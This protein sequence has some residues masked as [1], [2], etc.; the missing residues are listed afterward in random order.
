[1]LDDSFW[2]VAESAWGRLPLGPDGLLEGRAVYTDQEMARLL[3]RHPTPAD[4][5]ALHALK[6]ATGGVLTTTYGPA[7]ARPSVGAPRGPAVDPALARQMC[8]PY[9]ALLAL[10]REGKLPACD[11]ALCA[12]VRVVDANTKVLACFSELADIC[13]GRV[14]A[15]RWRVR[16]QERLADLARLLAWYTEVVGDQAAS[17]PA[18]A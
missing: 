14:A 13:E 16:I 5:C 18:A 9:Q 12:G 11:L 1:V 2:L 4:L 8:A 6:R 10:A 7:A 17:L 3:A 15:E